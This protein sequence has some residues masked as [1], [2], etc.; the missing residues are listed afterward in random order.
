MPDQGSYSPSAVTASALLLSLPLADFGGHMDWGGDWSALMVIGMVLFWGLIIVGIVWALRE[1][2]NS[3]ATQ[4][5]PE[6]N[7]LRTLDRRLAEGAISP[8]DY[9]ERRAILDDQ[10]PPLND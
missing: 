8:D 2:G 1:I 10:E 3:K 7:P 4:A 9:R 6:N 5:E